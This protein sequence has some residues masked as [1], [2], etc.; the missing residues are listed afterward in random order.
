M[1]FGLI[2]PF[3]G[4]N[5]EFGH[6]LSIGVEAAFNAVNEAGGIGP[7]RL[8]LVTADDGYEPSRTPDLV[9]RMAEKDGVVGF[10]GNFGTPTAAAVL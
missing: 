7:Y 5:K 8:K 2:A 3:S 9:K 4:A 6:Q 1:R 10:V